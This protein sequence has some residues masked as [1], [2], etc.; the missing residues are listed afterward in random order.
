MAQPPTKIAGP[1]LRAG[2][3]EVFVTGIVTR[4]I[5]VNA[6]PIAMAAVKAQMDV[7][8]DP[9]IYTRLESVSAD[10]ESAIGDVLAAA[11]GQGT[12][13][14]VG[15]LLQYVPEGGDTGIHGTGGLWSVI[16][17]GM[18]RRGF[19]FMPSGNIFL[20]VAHTTDDIDATAVAL[21]KVLAEA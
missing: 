13:N 21:D 6:N 3:T 17:E 10:F 11:V 9:E 18:V 14:R 1:V 20:S 12:L 7:L 5:R 2:L 16:L 19:L 15:S 4:W 8:A